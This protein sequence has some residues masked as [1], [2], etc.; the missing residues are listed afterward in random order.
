MTDIR[1]DNPASA[2]NWVRDSGNAEADA[3]WN[4]AHA[5]MKSIAFAAADIDGDVKIRCTLTGNGATY[6][7]ISVDDD[8]DASHTPA[9][10]DANDVF[11]IEN[12]DLKVTT[13][14]DNA[15]ILENSALKASGAKLNG[16]ITAESKLFASQPE[17]V[18]EFSYNHNGLRTQKKVT[19]ADG[20]VETTDYALHG[21]LLTHLTRDNDTMHFFYDNEKRPTMVEFNGTLYRANPRLC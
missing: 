19:K 7:T 8:L 16:S 9:E 10:L 4:A 21:K 20:T 11:A 17:D 1:R 5:G 6:G 15:Y 13:S 18:V 12:G 2:F 14:R 3:V